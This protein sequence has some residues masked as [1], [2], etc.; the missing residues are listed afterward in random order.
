MN[1]YDQSLTGRLPKG[2]A[3]N[4]NQLEAIRQDIMFVLTINTTNPYLDKASVVATDDGIQNLADRLKKVWVRRAEA[5]C[6]ARNRGW[7][8]VAK[9]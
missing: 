3:E 5:L 4:F 1:R 2:V 6:D 9:A 7:N 8:E